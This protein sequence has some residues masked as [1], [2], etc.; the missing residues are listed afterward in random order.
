MSDFIELFMEFTKPL[1][2]PENFFYWASLSC[3]GALL[4]DN[5]YLSFGPG[6]LYANTYVLLLADP[7][8]H[9]KSVPLN[10]VGDI[11]DRV[12]NTKVIRGR[13]TLAGIL[14]KLS[15][16][17]TNRD[18][19]HQ[20]TG[21][22][23]ILLAEELASF[24]VQDQEFIPRIT[25]L[26]DARPEWIDNLRGGSSH[27]KNLC[28]SMLAASNE[29]FLKRVYT[30]DAVFGGLLRRTF[31]VRPTGRKPPNSLFGQNGHN[32]DKSKLVDLANEISKLKGPVKPTDEAKLYYDS[33]YQVLYES[34]GKNG[35][36]SGIVE[37]LHVNVLK[38]ALIIAVGRRQEL[39][40]TKNDLDEATDKCI[41]IIPNYTTYSM[42]SGSNDTNKVGQYFLPEI[43][44]SENHEISRKLFLRK[45]FHEIDSDTL[46]NFIT[47]VREA[48]IIDEVIKTAGEIYYKLT[49]AGIGR[50]RSKLEA[51]EESE[52][53]RT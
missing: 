41:E 33:W 19:G 17:Q 46:D 4:R 3:I 5:V 16:P 45:Y 11:I 12:K 22:S 29:E 44:E 13:T 6:K 9:R 51:L 28:L 10:I 20:V 18:S 37:S 7:A 2:S 15:N 38:I 35:D 14:E 1:E 53:Q 21:G 31:F 34:Y 42:S 25:D 39:I 43:W 48:G 36:K 40:I 26:Y 47:T 49:A 32:Y 30:K 27:I 23:C 52:K 50:F 8:G 24:F